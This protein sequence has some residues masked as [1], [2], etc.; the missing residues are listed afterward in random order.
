MLKIKGFCPRGLQMLKSCIF[1]NSLRLISGF[2]V[3]R[4][5]VST[6]EFCKPYTLGTRALFFIAH[7]IF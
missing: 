1:V 2:E 3:G 5:D 4:F 7:G 6:V